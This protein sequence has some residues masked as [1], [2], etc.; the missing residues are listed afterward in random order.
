MHREQAGYEGTRTQ[1]KLGTRTQSP[2]CVAQRVAQDGG[3][4]ALTLCSEI[5]GLLLTSAS[6]ESAVLFQPSNGSSP[7]P[8]REC[9]RHKCGF[10][11]SVSPF[12]HYDSPGNI[13]SQKN[14]HSC[15]TLVILHVLR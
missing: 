3:G 11:A 9:P 1:S 12:S 4:Q 5:A 7:L 2:L 8:G 14:I 13:C 6:H 15:D 10:L